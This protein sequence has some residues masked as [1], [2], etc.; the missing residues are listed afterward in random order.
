ME[1]LGEVTLKCSATVTRMRKQ[2]E[3]AFSNRAHAMQSDE[4]TGKKR[5]QFPD[6]VL[7][8]HERDAKR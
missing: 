1:K 6:G 8:P 7:K 5:S 3:M 2:G 4:A